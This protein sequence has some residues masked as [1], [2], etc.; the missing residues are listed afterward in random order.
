MDQL[1]HVKKQEF[2]TLDDT[3][4]TETMGKLKILEFLAEMITN[5]RESLTRELIVN[6]VEATEDNTSKDSEEVQVI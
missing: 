1:L 5:M 4:K 2:K 6:E 3:A